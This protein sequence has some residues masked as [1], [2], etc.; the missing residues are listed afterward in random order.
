MLCL[1]RCTNFIYLEQYLIKSFWSL[2]AGNMNTNNA[3][4]ARCAD[5]PSTVAMCTLARGTGSGSGGWIKTSFVC[6]DGEYSSSE[7]SAVCC[8]LIVAKTTEVFEGAPVPVEIDVSKKSRRTH[9][10]TDCMVPLLCRS[11]AGT[12]GDNAYM[13]LLVDR[14]VISKSVSRSDER[15]K[16]S[17]NTV[18]DY[19][20]IAAPRPDWLSRSSVLNGIGNSSYYRGRSVASRSVSL[21]AVLR[22]VGGPRNMATLVMMLIT[23]RY[24][25]NSGLL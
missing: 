6:G 18:L 4:S 17:F 9:D 24:V 15:T 5:C 7:M 16:N 11:S 2:V 1:L 13:Q 10:T 25:K 23:G 8:S 20:K 22:L 14:D 12:C 3:T 21:L 19:Y